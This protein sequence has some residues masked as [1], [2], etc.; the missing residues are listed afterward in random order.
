M[1]SEVQKNEIKLNPLNT[2]S[3]NRCCNA[4][5]FATVLTSVG[6]IIYWFYNH[7]SDRKAG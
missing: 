2:K 1:A 7:H 5:K 4:V 3:N 6:L